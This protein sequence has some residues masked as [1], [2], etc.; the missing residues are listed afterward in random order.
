MGVRCHRQHEEHTICTDAKANTL[1]FKCDPGGL[2]GFCTQQTCVWSFSVTCFPPIKLFL[3]RMIDLCVVL[4][5]GFFVL[6]FLSMWLYWI[7]SRLQ[8]VAALHQLAPPNLQSKPIGCNLLTKMWSIHLY[9]EKKKAMLIALAWARGWNSH[10]TFQF[11]FRI[12]NGIN[13]LGS[14]WTASCG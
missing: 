3:E 1:Y 13:N 12:T 7:L 5:T 14:G 4:F 10:F 11:M 2:G 6:T 9:F 8:F